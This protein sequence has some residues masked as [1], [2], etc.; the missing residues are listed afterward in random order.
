MVVANRKSKTMTDARALRGRGAAE[1]KKARSSA[2]IVSK[3]HSGARR[4]GPEHTLTAT[5]RPDDQPLESTNEGSKFR[6]LMIFDSFVS[7]AGSSQYTSEAF[8]ELLGRP[9]RIQGIIRFS[10]VQGG[11]PQAT[12]RFETSFDGVRYS[13][14]STVGPFP[15]SSGMSMWLTSTIIPLPNTFLRGGITITSGSADVRGW[16]T[17]LMRGRRRFGV[18]A[19]DRVLTAG[20]SF[21]SASDF[22]D[23]FGKVDM[24]SLVVAP[25]QVDGTS[26]TLTLDLEE[27]PDGIEWSTKTTL[28]TAVPI[29]SGNLFELEDTGSVPASK[30]LRLRAELGG[31]APVANIRIY[32]VGRGS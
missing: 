16:A 23:M 19:L 24:L 29:S 20:S 8:A 17:S 13:L 28:L 26:V 3:G 10:D 31:T 5:K 27:S 7:S 4:Q 32:V 12:L 30:F 9:D 14:L 21:Y 15:I 18:L 1:Q 25:D 2:N 11:S 6:S 22:N